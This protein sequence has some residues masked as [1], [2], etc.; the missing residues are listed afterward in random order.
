M[1]EWYVY[2]TLKPL[3]LLTSELLSH[4]E[5]H[6]DGPSMMVLTSQHVPTEALSWAMHGQNT[7]AKYLTADSKVSEAS[8]GGRACQVRC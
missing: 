1:I 4:R 6:L 8:L 2:C 7:D 3:L 5:P